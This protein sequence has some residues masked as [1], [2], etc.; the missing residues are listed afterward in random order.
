MSF[1]KASYTRFGYQERLRLSLNV[2]EPHNLQF[3]LSHSG[4]FVF[5]LKMCLELGKPLV[6]KNKGEKKEE[7]KFISSVVRFWFGF[8][9]CF[10]FSPFAWFSHLLHSFKVSMWNLL[11]VA[12][13]AAQLSLVLVAG[14]LCRQY[15]S[16]F[17]IIRNYFITLC[18]YGGNQTLRSR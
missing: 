9:V 12:H 1:W 16:T 8:V 4:L 17:C 11:F 7:R 2:S 18:F 15:P 3:A 6:I 14:F 5:K 13:W 10:V